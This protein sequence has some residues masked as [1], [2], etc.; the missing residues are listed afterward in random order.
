MSED[1]SKFDGIREQENFCRCGA[2]FMSHTKF[3]RLQ[4]KLRLITQKPC[5]R[6]GRNDNVKR[7]VSPS[8]RL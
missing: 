6:C 8:G 5:P 4:D 2:V 1:W 3:A 7:S